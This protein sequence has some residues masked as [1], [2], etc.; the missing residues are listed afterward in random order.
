MT[1]FTELGC[2]C[3]SPGFP[4]SFLIWALIDWQDNL[5]VGGA[6]R[7]LRVPAV[8]LQHFLS[9]GASMPHCLWLK[10]IKLIHQS[11][12]AWFG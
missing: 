11:S 10:A 4:C 12:T 7:L 3:I 2:I 6:V 8:P 1:D 5:N 9:G